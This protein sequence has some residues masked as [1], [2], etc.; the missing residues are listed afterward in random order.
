MEFV[1]RSPDNRPRIGSISVPSR[2]SD[3]LRSVQAGKAFSVGIVN[4]YRLYTK[5]AQSRGPENIG[6]ERPL[7]GQLVA[8]AVL[9]P[10]RIT[11]Q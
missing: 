9:S 5:S 2:G 4:A 6:P 7:L 10:I 8:G 3:R 11:I 1:D